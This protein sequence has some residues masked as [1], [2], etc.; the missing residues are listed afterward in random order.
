MNRQII[1]TSLGH[2]GVYSW[3]E[4]FKM[5]PPQL[6]LRDEKAV[7]AECLYLERHNLR[8]EADSLLELHCL[9]T[10]SV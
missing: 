6:N 7:L 3:T 8:E 10:E 9:I 1:K 5:S 4:G 2:Y